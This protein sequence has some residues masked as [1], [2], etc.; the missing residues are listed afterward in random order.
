[1][2]E[3]APLKSVEDGVSLKPLLGQVQPKPAVGAEQLPPSLEQAWLKPVVVAGQA[4]CGLPGEARA[5]AAVGARADASARSPSSGHGSEKTRRFGAVAENRGCLAWIANGKI[6]KMR[7]VSR[8][9]AKHYPA[10]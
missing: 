4:K 2:L 6:R 3:L 1:M 7:E 9:T 10:G 8:K 5:G